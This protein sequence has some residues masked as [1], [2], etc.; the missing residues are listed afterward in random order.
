MTAGTQRSD[1]G[2][3]PIPAPRRGT[4]GLDG[5]APEQAP[6]HPTPARRGR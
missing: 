6:P 3:R 2:S 1:A 4:D 5:R